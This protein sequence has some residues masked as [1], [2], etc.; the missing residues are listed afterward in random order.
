LLVVIAII[1]ILA[2]MLLPALSKAKEKARTINCV[3]N[4][5]QLGLAMKL[6][7]G[8]NNG[9]FMPLWRQ[10]GAP[11]T[12]WTYDASTFIVQNPAGLF[13]EDALRLSGFSTSRKIFDCPAMKVE[14]ALNQGGSLSDLN[15][16]GIGLNFPEYGI[17]VPVASPPP[18]STYRKESDT[19]KPSESVVFADSGGVQEPTPVGD[20]DNWTEYRLPDL[21]TGVGAAFFRSPSAGASFDSGDNGHPVRAIPRHGRRVNVAHLDGRA[22]NVRNSNLG[23][24]YPRGDARALWDRE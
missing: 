5:R 22:E 9:V 13:W 2:A 14:K 15:A 20:G 6:Y 16:L 11:G 18:S 7:L 12:A 24:R 19:R 23:W 17:T 21:F 4:M 3:S 8:D 1:A 10:P